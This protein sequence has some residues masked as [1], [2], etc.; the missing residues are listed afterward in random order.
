MLKKS[1]NPVFSVYYYYE[2][3]QSASKKFLDEIFGSRK[4]NV[5]TIKNKEAVKNVS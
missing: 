3:S 2:I 4:R 5:T 1:E